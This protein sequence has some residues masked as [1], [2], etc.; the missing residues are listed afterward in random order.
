MQQDM[1]KLREFAERYA[2]AWCRQDPTKVASFYSPTGSLRVNADAP[3]VDVLRSPKSLALSWRRSQTCRSC[4]TM[5][6]CAVTMLNF[7]GR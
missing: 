1:A 4:W 5:F 6:A 3:A 2:A 7:I